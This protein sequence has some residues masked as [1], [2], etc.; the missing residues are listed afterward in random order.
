LR[1]QCD[2]YIKEFGIKPEDMVEVSYSDMLLA[3]IK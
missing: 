2:H 1:T 3:E